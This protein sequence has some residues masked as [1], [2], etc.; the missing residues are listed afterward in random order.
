MFLNICLF[1]HASNSKMLDMKAG[2]RGY[3]K[4]GAGSRDG[5]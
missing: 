4:E 2:G 3:R 1:V 5:R